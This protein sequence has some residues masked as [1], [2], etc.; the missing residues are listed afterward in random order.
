MESHANLHL[1][2]NTYG[3][4]MG[5]EGI[6]RRFGAERLIFGTGLPNYEVGGP[7]ALVAYADISDGDRARIAGG[8]LERLLG[9]PRGEE[10]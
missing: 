6:V 2:A 7:M 3:A 4:F 8:N 10:Q 5:V 1:E 9:R